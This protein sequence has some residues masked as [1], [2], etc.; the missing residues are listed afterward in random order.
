LIIYQLF[1]IGPGHL[2][3]FFMGLSL[4]AAKNSVIEIIPQLLLVQK[5]G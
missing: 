2:I 5:N 4:Q 1:K 3:I